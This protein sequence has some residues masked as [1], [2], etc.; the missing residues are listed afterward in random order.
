MENHLRVQSEVKCLF[1]FP[2]DGDRGCLRNAE[3]CRTD[4]ADCPRTLYSVRLLWKLQAVNILSS[5]Y[6][7]F[8]HSLVAACF[9]LS[10][11]PI[12][13]LFSVTLILSDCVYFVLYP[14]VTLL[15]SLFHLAEASFQRIDL[16]YLLINEA[17][18]PFFFSNN[19]WKSD[20]S[21]FYLNLSLVCWLRAA[22]VFSWKQNFPHVIPYASI[23]P[24]TQELCD[25]TFVYKSALHVCFCR[26]HVR[27]IGLCVYLQPGAK[28]KQGFNEF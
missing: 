25:A 6:S 14:H 21:L 3:R 8:L 15:F 7:L 23:E 2:D 13:F 26:W 4:A 24:K 12:S 16:R 19:I 22:S 17:V 5:L 27:L 28:I 20:E 11:P 10:P 9:D 1:L 18:F